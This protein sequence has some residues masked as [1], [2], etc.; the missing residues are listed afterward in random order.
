MLTVG[1]ENIALHRV[2]G[3]VWSEC[4]VADLPRSIEEA[5]WY[6]RDERTSGSHAGAHVGAGR[7][8]V[9]AHGSG[10]QDEDRKRRLARFFHKVDDA[11]MHFLH[12][13]PETPLVIAGTVPSVARY[14]LTTRHHHIVAAPIGSPEEITSTELHQ[15]VNELL[16]PLAMQRNEVMLERLAVR[17]STGLASS[18]MTE[19]VVAAQQGR[20]SDLLVASTMPVW[21]AASPPYDR[22]DA[23]QPGATDLINEIVGEAWRHGARIHAVPAERL[24]EDVQVAALYRY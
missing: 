9:I 19:L 13:D 14:Q 17:A 4:H 8:S 20:V 1:A 11:V 5:L 10:A 12:D 21:A 22:L 6:E 15:R 18:D 7:M 23:W 3:I 24:A 2:D 16:E